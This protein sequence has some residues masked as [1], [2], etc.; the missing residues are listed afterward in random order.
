LHIKD[1]A[2]RFGGLELL[3]KESKKDAK[4]HSST[5][6]LNGRRAGS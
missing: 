2:H 1:V 4:K 3:E 5:P 6:W